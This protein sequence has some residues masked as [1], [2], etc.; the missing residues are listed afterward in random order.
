LSFDPEYVS[1]AQV[2]PGL[3]GPFPPGIHVTRSIFGADKL[4]SEI[5]P[6]LPLVDPPAA[7]FRGC[8]V[9]KKCAGVGLRTLLHFSVRINNIGDAE[10]ILG[11]AGAPGVSTALCDGAVYNGNPPP[12]SNPLYR[13]DYLLY[14]LLDASSTPVAQSDGLAP[15]ICVPAAQSTSR[16]SCEFLGL[17]KG[18]SE[19]FDVSSECQWLDITGVPPGQYTLRLSVNPDRHLRELSYD[20]NTFDVPV[21]LTAPDLLAACPG[22]NDRRVFSVSALRDCGWSSHPPQS[23]AP[24][25]LVDLGCP[26]CMGDTVLRVCEGTEPCTSDQALAS[27]DDISEANLCAVTRFRCP[28]SGTYNW[29]SGLWFGNDLDS[30]ACA[31]AELPR[32]T[33]E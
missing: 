4:G 18:S 13:T 14:Q 7:A 9:Q 12:L 1:P 20:N 33:G 17:A 29:M 26:D 24:G 2:G 27:G 3:T 31:A 5:N 23:C 16:F 19:I 28:P 10:L 32:V 6:I 21:S 22:P 25:T 11:P 30:T 15:A 8:A